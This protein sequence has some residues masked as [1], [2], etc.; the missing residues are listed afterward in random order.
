MLRHILIKLIKIKD[1]E[2]ILTVA[3]EK[4]E[5]TYRGTLIS[6]LADFSAENL[7]ARVARN[8]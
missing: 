6:L 2:K 7:Q 3:R 5:I 1:K 4:K 8:T